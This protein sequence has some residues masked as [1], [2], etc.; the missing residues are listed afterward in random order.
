VS[1][2]KRESEVFCRCEHACMW[3][4]KDSFVELVLPPFCE[5]GGLIKVIRFAWQTLGLWNH[6][7]SPQP[8]F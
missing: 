6:L 4:P 2:P 8:R 5:F 3:K 1:P 7:I